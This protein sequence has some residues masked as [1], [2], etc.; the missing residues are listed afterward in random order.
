MM[1]TICYTL[2]PILLARV[3]NVLIFCLIRLV[4]TAYVYHWFAWCL[5][6]TFPLSR[7]LAALDPLTCPGSPSY[8]SPHL[9]GCATPL[10]HLPLHQFW[11][12]WVRSVAITKISSGAYSVSYQASVSPRSARWHI[13]SASCDSIFLWLGPPCIYSVCTRPELLQTW[14]PCNPRTINHI[15][16]LHSPALP[17]SSFTSLSLCLRL[18]LKSAIWSNYSI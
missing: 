2:G 12:A 14:S 8:L 16:E 18:S 9:H 13:A 5:Y 17:K 4:W 3:S 15:L 7:Y 11:H 6:Q 1:D 10:A